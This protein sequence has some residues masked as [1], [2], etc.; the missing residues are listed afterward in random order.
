VRERKA[1]AKKN[2]ENYRAGFYRQSD[3][4]QS[5]HRS[6]FGD[7]PV[8]TIVFEERTPDSVLD[9]LR[10]AFPEAKLMPRSQAEKGFL[11]PRQ[12]SRIRPG[13]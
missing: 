12:R 5:W 9:E 6:M 1:I 10:S 11:H 2:I 7:R 3:A 4:A 13:E 8:T